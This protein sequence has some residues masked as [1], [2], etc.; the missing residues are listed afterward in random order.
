MTAAVRRFPRSLTRGNK[1]T[2]TGPSALFFNHYKISSDATSSSSPASIRDNSDDIDIPPPPTDCC[3][4]GCANCVWVVYAE[5][6]ARIYKDG[7][8]AAEKVLAAVEDPSLKI[9]L[10]LEL[11][12]K[13]REHGE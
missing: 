13:L 6:L 4:S 2:P 10:S 12:E 3:M 1:C 8:R 11:R 5:E 9:F 7:G